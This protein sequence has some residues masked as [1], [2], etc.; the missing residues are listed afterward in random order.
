MPTGFGG[1]SSIMQMM[2]EDMLKDMGEMA[3]GGT[4]RISGGPGGLGGTMTIR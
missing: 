3:G 4:I 2:M 1:P